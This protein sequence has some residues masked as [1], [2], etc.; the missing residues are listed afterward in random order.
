MVYLPSIFTKFLIPPLLSLTLL[1]LHCVTAAKMG[2]IGFSNTLAL[3]GSKYNIYSNTIVPTAWSRMTTNVMPSGESRKERS[4][5]WGGEEGQGGV[6][7]RGERLG[8]RRLRQGV[9]RFAC[10]R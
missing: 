7:V 8:A 4:Q 3:E 1:P 10:G 2:L 9:R 6:R 5:G